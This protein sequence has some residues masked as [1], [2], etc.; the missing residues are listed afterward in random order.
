[1][2]GDFTKLRYVKDLS[3]AS[4]RLLQN[5]EHTGRQLKGTMEVR[6]MMRFQTHAGRIRR[7]VPIFLTFSPD[8][9]HNIFMLRF[10]RAREND[11]I[12]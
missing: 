11:P 1:M 9:K 4:K 10:Y 7:G 3:E 8:E 12:H 2:N 6:K 5:L